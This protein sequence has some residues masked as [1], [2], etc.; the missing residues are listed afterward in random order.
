MHTARQLKEEQFEIEIDGRP[1]SRDEFL[2]EWEPLHR[3]GVVI[4][5]PFGAVGASFALQLAITAFYDSRPIRRSRETPIYPDIYAFHVGGRHGDFINYDFFP[6]RKEVFVASEPIEI[7]AAVNDRSITHLLV[8]ERPI[9]SVQHEFKEPAQAI[10]RIVA[11]WVYSPSGRV[12]GA[13]VAITG[14]AP[15]A[16]ANTKV[17]LNAPDAFRERRRALELVGEIVIPDDELAMV[18]D[19]RKDEVSDANRDRVRKLRDALK[20]P[21]GWTETYRRCSTREALG[22]LH[23]GEPPAFREQPDFMAAFEA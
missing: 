5:E 8:P 16:E 19:D 22:M 14:T 2:V 7:L 9:D 10:D 13:D 21:R 15:A 12:D 17:T 11:A 3:L 23:V 4:H 18:P 20:G 6:A 1:A